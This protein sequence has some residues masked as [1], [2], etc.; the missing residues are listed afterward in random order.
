VSVAAG[1]D[2]QSAINSNPGGTTFC[3]QPGVY[4]LSGP[5]SPQSGDVIDG[6]GRQAVLNGAKVITGWQQSGSA[7]VASGYLPTPY[8]DSNYDPCEDQ[9]NNHCKL[10]EWAFRDNNHLNRVMS[11]SAVGPGTFYTDYNNNLVY[12]GDNPSGHNLEISSARQAIEVAAANV[13]IR[14]LTVEKFASPAQRGAV[15]A[16]ADSTTITNDEFRF[17][18]G[19]GLY[20]YGNNLHVTASRMHDNGMVG[21]GAFNVSGLV[22]TGNELDHNNTDGFWIND[23][24]NG[25]FK[26]TNSSGEDI[27]NNNAHDNVGMGLWFDISDNHDTIKGNT[28]AHNAA[29][30]IRYEISGPALITQNTVTGNGFNRGRTQGGAN[31]LYYG[32]GLTDS[33]GQGVEISYNTL[34]GNDN[35][36]GLVEQSRGGPNLTNTNVHDNTITM[37]SGVTGLQQSVSDNSYF[38]SQGNSFTHNTYHLNPTTGTFFAWL[39]QVIPSTQWVAGGQ[40]TTGT[41]GL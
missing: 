38:T 15:V 35:G 27:E 23:G 11:V 31:N 2:V 7:W 28:T 8:T 33:N 29:D 30:G 37:T 39:N 32:A 18:H 12:V 21:I 13:T 22:V 14:N 5:L 4:R 1:Q 36:I 16:N 25:G 41:F 17:N 40:D 6:A 9:N 20:D 24:E 34:S 19:A 26:S 3:L 10:D